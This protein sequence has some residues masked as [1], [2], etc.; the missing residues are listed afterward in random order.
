MIQTCLSHYDDDSSPASSNCQGA[1]NRLVLRM[2]N[3]ELDH[4]AEFSVVDDDKRNDD[5]VFGTEE[6]HTANI[7][8][9][10]LVGR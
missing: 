3:I 9:F 6:H 4:T 8:F 5:E 10:Y 2:K 1:L 7:V